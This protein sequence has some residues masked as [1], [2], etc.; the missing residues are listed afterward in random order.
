MPPLKLVG[1]QQAMPPARAFYEE[2]SL[3]DEWP[4]GL[5]RGQNLAVEE[6][7]PCRRMVCDESPSNRHHQTFDHS[8]KKFRQTSFASSG[9]DFRQK[10]A[11]VG[12][13]CSALVEGH[14]LVAEAYFS[15]EL[16]LPYPSAAVEGYA[17]ASVVSAWGYSRNRDCWYCYCCRPWLRCMCF[18][19]KRYEK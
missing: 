3:C 4:T 10:S 18:L 19:A 5:P 2:L 7:G 6:V 17:G 1:A 12:W 8:E 13:S 9:A 16:P 14:L 15:S 11:D